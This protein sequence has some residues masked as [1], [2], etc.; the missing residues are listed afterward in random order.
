MATTA[1]LREAKMTDKLPAE[2]VEEFTRSYPVDVEGLADA[3]D[4][5]VMREELPGDISG[6]IERD[7]IDSEGFMI[8]LNANHGTVRQRFTLAHE[9]AHFILH[10]DMIGDGIIDNGLYRDSRIGDG[11]ERQANRYAARILM[12]RRLVEKAWREAG[13]R[14]AVRLSAEFEVSQAVAQIRMTELGCVLW[15]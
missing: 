4:I 2:I 15:E 9:I 13:A 12:P 1:L 14:D 6:K 7:W 11:K 3:L 10:R 5:R 8:T